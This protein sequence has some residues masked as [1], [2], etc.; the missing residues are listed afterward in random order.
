MPAKGIAAHFTSS[1]K[2]SLARSRGGDGKGKARAKAKAAPIRLRTPEAGEVE[3]IMA[4]T[5]D[6]AQSDEPP[7]TADDP[8]AALL[9]TPPLK[10]PVPE[11]THRTPITVRTD[12]DTGKMF[13]RMSR[14]SP[15]VTP[16]SSPS[17]RKAEKSPTVAVSPSKTPKVRE[18]SPRQLITGEQEI[19]GSVEE[20]GLVLTPGRASGTRIA[21]GSPHKSPLGRTNGNEATLRRVSQ[22]QDEENY[23]TPRSIRQKPKGLTLPPLATQTAAAIF[24]SGHSGEPKPVSQLSSSASLPSL[25]NPPPVVKGEPVAEE[26]PLPLPAHQLSPDLPLP[27]YYASLLKLH[28]ALEH[29]LVFQLATAGCSSASLQQEAESDPESDDDLPAKLKMGPR[30]P[31]NSSKTVRLPNLITYSVLRPRVEQ[32]GKRRLGPT[33]LKRLASVW[34]NFPEALGATPDEVK[35]LGLLITKTRTEDPTTGRKIVDWGIG[36]ELDIKRVHRE[37]TPPPQLGFGGL[38]SACSSPIAGAA[39][40]FDPS[41]PGTPKAPSR[42]TTP[43]SSPSLSRRP[44]SSPSLGRHLPMSPPVGRRPPSSPSIDRSPGGARLLRSPGKSR[45]SAS[46]IKAREGMSV[47]AMWSNGLEVRKAEVA[48]RLRDRCARY[49]QQWLTDKCIMPHLV[50]VKKEDDGSGDAVTPVL[51]ELEEERKA[52]MGAGGLWTPSATRSGGRRAG[53]RTFSLDPSQLDRD[54]S[55]SD[56]ESAPTLSVLPTSQADAKRALMDEVNSAVMRTPRSQTTTE[57]AMPPAGSVLHAWHAEFELNNPAVVKPVPL[58]ELPSLVEPRSLATNGSHSLLATPRRNKELFGLGIGNLSTPRKPV[59][60]SQVDLPPTAPPTSST[61][62]SIAAMRERLQ[63]KENL[64]KSQSMSSISTGSMQSRKAIMPRLE[65]V[66]RIL[67]M[68]FSNGT[69]RS[70]TGVWMSPRKPMSEVLDTLGRSL[71]SQFSRIECREAVDLLAEI[72][73]GFLVIFQAGIQDS[74]QWVKMGTHQDGH[75]WTASQVKHQIDQVKGR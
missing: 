46:Q 25:L 44:P 74:Q 2:A 41:V 50:A 26:A 72:A 22:E 20:D 53:K 17:K 56:G 38:E 36:I 16:T 7:P 24:R 4:E 23:L 54:E 35:G 42:F 10:S 73:P 5:P 30:K 63:A 75:P 48:R 34:L 40:T 29:A 33:E 18:T 70:S 3:R 28:E 52:V 60:F 45:S 71:N 57:S 11:A 27:D 66:S 9:G 31:R 59:K 49:H 21:L 55:D 43:P 69:T 19:P 13:L 12:P 6:M 61:G 8:S 37:R 32:S 14:S 58:A 64:R 62:N 15:S 67:F 1:G 51:G 68:L 47:V 39:A 65:N